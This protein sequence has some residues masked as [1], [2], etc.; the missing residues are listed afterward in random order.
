MTTNPA[1]NPA[2]ITWRKATYSNAGN[3]CVEVARTPAGY[4][5]RDSKNPQAPHLTLGAAAWTSLLAAIKTN[6]P[7]C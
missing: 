1:T 4:A 6:A 5:I 2:T 3:E 7:I